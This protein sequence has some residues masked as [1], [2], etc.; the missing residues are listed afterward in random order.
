MS[1]V[2]VVEDNLEVGPTLCAMLEY[3]G[4]ACSFAGNGADAI[5]MLNKGG[6]E[7]VVTDVRLPGGMSGLEIADRAKAAG[8]GCVLITGY[9]DIMSDLDQ[10][11]HYI[12]LAKPFH[13]HALAEAVDAARELAKAIGNS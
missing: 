5:A 2:L 13:G 8:V 1:H 11:Q 10:Q 9:G 3:Y 7:V 4:H 6:V 12:W